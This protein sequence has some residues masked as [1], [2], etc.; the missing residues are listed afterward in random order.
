M[1]I[2]ETQVQTVKS[3]GKLV[4]VNLQKT[5]KDRFAAIKIHAPVDKVILAVMA[6]LDIPIPSFT[7]TLNLVTE[8]EAA[9]PEGDSTKSGEIEAL[10]YP[11]CGKDCP[12]PLVDA[13]RFWWDGHEGI[14]VSSSFLI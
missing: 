13:V 3:G 5:P 9:D 11:A 10:I 2:L 14:S 6:A 8:V 7:R 12:M 4:L 1:T